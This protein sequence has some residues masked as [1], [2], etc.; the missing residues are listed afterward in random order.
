MLVAPSSIICLVLA[1]VPEC[2]CTARRGNFE[3]TRSHTSK[4]LQRPKIREYFV[5]DG[6]Q[7]VG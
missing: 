7:G 3:S 2:C 5:M 1:A 4:Y 6:L